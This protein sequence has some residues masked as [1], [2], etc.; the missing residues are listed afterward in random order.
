MVLNI[1]KI[2]KEFTRR[3]LTSAGFAKKIGMT[4]QGFSHIMKEK[5]TSF[6]RLERIAQELEFDA[7]DLLV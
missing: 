6:P 4:R 3:G 1:S 5:R 7:K 2:E